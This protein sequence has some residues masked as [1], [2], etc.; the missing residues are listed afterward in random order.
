MEFCQ[1]A[2][3]IFIRSRI[4]IIRGGG[5]ELWNTKLFS[6]WLPNEGEFRQL[7]V[8]VFAKKRQNI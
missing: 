8:F 5:G 6:S 3:K 1:K 7:L 2:V 4:I